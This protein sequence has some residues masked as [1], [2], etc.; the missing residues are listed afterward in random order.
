[1]EKRRLGRTEQQSSVVIFGAAGIGKV[2]QKDADRA[3]QIALDHGVNH[4]DVAPSYGEAELR[5]RPWIPRI[6]EK[7]FLACKTTKRQKADAA[8]EL[9]RSLDRVQTGHFDLY[10]LHSVND[11]DQLDLATGPGG[12]VE[13]LVEAREEG[14]VAN[15]GIT[16]HGMQAPALHA[17]ALTRFDFDT[18]MFPLNP[19]LWGDADYRK[20]CESLMEIARDKDVGLM[21]IKA[22]AKEPWGDRERT[23]TTWYKPFE[24]QESIDRCVHFVLSQGITALASA[25]D[26]GLLPKILDAA[27]RFQPLAEGEQDGIVDAYRKLRQIFVT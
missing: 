17:E 13:A 19:T 10:Q 16:G 21:V 15:L 26:V 24:D 22:V 18:V 1:M 11:F 8:R 7:V 4:I 9:R 2:K 20:D 25:G 27:D 3:I 5:L 6:R 23:T 14:L 12:A